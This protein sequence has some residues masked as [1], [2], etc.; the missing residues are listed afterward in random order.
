M[1]HTITPSQMRSLES[2]VIAG[3]GLPSILLMEH[4]AQAVA[5]A[6]R[7]I[8]SHG[9]HAL[10]VCGPDTTALTD[11]EARLAERF[12]ANLRMTEAMRREFADLVD[13]YKRRHNGIDILNEYTG[14]VYANKLQAR[15]AYAALKQLLLE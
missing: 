15:R 5:R 4:A 2:E 11:N 12:I 6:M 9:A 1:L 13:K 10:F 8:V 7:A 3:V 14:G